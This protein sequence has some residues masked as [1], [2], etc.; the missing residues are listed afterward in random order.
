MSEDKQGFL[1]RADAH[2]F[3]A[4]EQMN[5]DISSGEVS[6]S[7]MFALA[8]F[9]AWIAASSYKSSEDM[10]VEKQKAMDYFMN[11]YKIMLEQ[12]LDE[13]IKGFNFDS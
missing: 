13:H 11:E 12:H 10:A 5:E 6:A 8:R 4:N 7:F 9:N 3:L 1:K 2:I